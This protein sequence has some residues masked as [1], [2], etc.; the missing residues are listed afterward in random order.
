MASTQTS[1]SMAAVESTEHGEF[2]FR[3]E[4]AVVEARDGR[5]VPVNAEGT[6]RCLVIRV[7]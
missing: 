7:G 4:R 6:V 1:D 5:K 2:H 3:R